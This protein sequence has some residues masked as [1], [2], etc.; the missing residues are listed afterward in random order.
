MCM[1]WLKVM[2]EHKP[3]V[4]VSSNPYSSFVPQ[5][6]HLLNVERVPECGD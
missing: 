3:R 4:S 1:D 6:P 2:A 5:F